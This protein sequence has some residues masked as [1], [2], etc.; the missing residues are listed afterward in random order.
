MSED[1]LAGL[2]ED[3]A[4]LCKS[5][6]Q[7]LAAKEEYDDASQWMQFS[8]FATLVSTMVA[9][10]NHPGGMTIDDLA[11]MYLAT[12]TTPAQNEP[13]EGRG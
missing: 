6:A 9:A 8:A 13:A 4:E 11:E 10:R 7:K 1:E 2:F 12:P 5:V 3:L